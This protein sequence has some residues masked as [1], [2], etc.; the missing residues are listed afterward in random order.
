[1][2]FARLSPDS[3]WVAF[4]WYRIHE[5]SDVFVV[6]S[7]GSAP[8]VALTH[9]SEYTKLVSWAPD[10]L[11]V[12]VSEDHDGD[13]LARLYRVDIEKPGE[14]QPLTEDRPLYFIR[15]GDLGPHGKSL[16][17]G[18]NYDFENERALEPTWVYKHDLR[19]GERT[20]LARPE[21]PNY[22]DISVNDPGTHVLYST[23]ERHPAGRQYHLVGV[24]GMNNREILNFGDQVKV[25]A[26]WLPD[27][28]NILFLSESTGE[29]DKQDHLSLGV[30]HWPGETVRWLIDDPDRMIESIRVSPDGAVVVD[31][32]R[33]ARHIPAYLDIESGVG[34]PF[35]E[36]RGNLLPIGRAADGAWI[37]MYYSATSPV[38]LGRFPERA[39][40]QEDFT[41][42]TRVWEHTELRPERLIRAEDFRWTS[43]DG[44][45]IQGW[46]YRAQPNPKRAILYIHGGP[47]YHSEDRLNAQIQYF[48]S[49]GFNVLDV[50]YRGS[51]GFGLKFRESIKVDGWGGREQDDIASGARALI[52]EGLAQPGRIGVT[53]TS[54][55][56][57]SSW[58]QITGTPIDVVAAAAPIC[59]MTDLVVDYET[60]R[61]D[62]RPYSEE[63]I[64]GRPDQIPEK[65]AERSPINAIA[66]IRGQLLVVQGALDPNV[67]PENVRVVRERLESAGIPYDLLVF[68]DEGH[69]IAK[70]ANQE[71]LYRRLA[72]F[73][74]R[75]LI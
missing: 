60:T 26:R 66:D 51:T 52:R 37:A 56:G 6:P 42:L 64:G 12:V 67:T 63:M 15:G 47:T 31:E 71:K 69:G 28:E 24:E 72:E 4:D 13:E 29:G 22:M 11:S 41:S 68:E 54:Y 25:S 1:V 9:T 62:L 34:R 53:G 30:Y 40:S 27:G 43:T 74:D 75:F 73:F 32:I 16:Y 7:D 17:Y 33:E 45:E 2:Q 65:Y 55:G 38:E 61:P 70:P 21:Q 8:P 50:N 48:V 35:P 23:K 3:R 44:Q 5:N 19:T 49:Q 10:S 58:R 36:A 57:Y 59:G 46:L 20:A 39:S 18:A 14:M